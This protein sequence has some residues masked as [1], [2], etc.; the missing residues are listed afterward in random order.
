[1]NEVEII[2]TGKNTAGPAFKE[3]QRDADKL[4]RNLN[5]TERERGQTRPGT[6]DRRP[7]LA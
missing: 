7:G 4:G 6:E 3:A 1:V 5:S 2:I